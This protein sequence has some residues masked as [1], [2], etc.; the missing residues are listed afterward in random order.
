MNPGGGLRAALA[1]RPSGAALLALSLV[2]LA[3]FGVLG[4]GRGGSIPQSDFDFFYAGG[5]CWRKGE[6]PYRRENLQR[7]VLELLVLEDA[8]FPYPPQSAAVY[9]PFALF[10]HPIAKWLWLLLALVSAGAIAWICAVPLLGPPASGRSGG[11]GVPMLVAA[12]I[13]GCPF[14]AHAAWLGGSCLLAAA[15][16]IAS[17]TCLERGRPGIG[18]IL[19]GLA[20]FKP[21]LALLPILWLILE[22]RWKV[23]AVGAG[24]ALLMAVPAMVVSGPVGA[25]TEWLSALSYSSQRKTLDGYWTQ[26][27]LDRFLRSLGLVVPDLLPLAIL[28][29]VA[30]WLIRT[31][32]DRRDVFPLLMGIAFQFIYLHDTDLVTLYPI[33]PAFVRH[34]RDRPPALGLAGLLAAVVCFP[35][36]FIRSFDFE[37]LAF[38]RIPALLALV[39]WLLL[40]SMRRIRE[41][42]GTPEAQAPPPGLETSPT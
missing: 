33:V 28:S 23:L 14:T 13:L 8:G 19:L 32:I 9:V 25:F 3:S 18:G 10:S 37:V 34:L 42:A 12:L 35:T 21:Q 31:R 24:T 40:L 5:R 2:A 1:S 7:S 30:L 6:S 29:T 26:M 22:R 27:G 39:V 38:L 41:S 17:W 4:V 36:R 20:T 15:F 11:P 16:L